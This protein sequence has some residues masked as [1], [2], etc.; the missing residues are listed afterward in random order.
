MW[1][2]YDSE[3]RLVLT[4][5]S[6]HLEPSGGRVDKG[7]RGIRETNLMGKQGNESYE[8]VRVKRAGIGTCLRFHN[9]HRNGLRF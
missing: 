7:L 4:E 8:C 3:T 2:G 9:P 6:D 1:S 5:S